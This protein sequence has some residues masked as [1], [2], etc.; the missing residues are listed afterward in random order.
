[1]TSMDIVSRQIGGVYVTRHPSNT[2]S[3]KKPYEAVPYKMQKAMDTLNKYAF[4]S[5]GLKPLESVAAYMQRERRGFDFYDE[6][7]DPK[8][9]DYILSVTKEFLII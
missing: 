3:A 2:K 4:N 7:E 9:H 6:N 8:F 5:E 1:M